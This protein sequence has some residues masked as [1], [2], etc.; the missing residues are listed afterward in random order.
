MA[1]MLIIIGKSA[2]RASQGKQKEQA[3]KSLHTSPH[4][5]ASVAAHRECV[6]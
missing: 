3:E 4:S 2:G 5:A 1:V 6:N